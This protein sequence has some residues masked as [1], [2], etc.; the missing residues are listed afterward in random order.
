MYLTIIAYFMIFESFKFQ[1]KK[2]EEKKR[3]RTT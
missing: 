2:K 3:R 1:R